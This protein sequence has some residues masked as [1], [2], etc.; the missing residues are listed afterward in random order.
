MLQELLSRKRPYYDRDSDIQVMYAIIHGV[1]PVYDRTVD[2]DAEVLGME[3]KLLDLCHQ[4][5]VQE[6]KDRLSRKL[7]ERN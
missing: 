6:P 5:W 4:C 2:V 7:T 3:D 1:L